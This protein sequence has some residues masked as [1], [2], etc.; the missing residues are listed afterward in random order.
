[1]EAIILAGGMGTRLSKVVTDVPKPMAPVNGKPFLLY[2]L[3]WIKKNPIEKIILSVGYKSESIV[4]YFGKSFNDIPVI[5]VIEEKPLG[6]GGALKFALKKTKGKNVLALNGDS[7]F[8]IDLNKFILEH[9]EN[10]HLFS[11]A[12][13]R[14]KGFSRYGSVK[15]LGNTI[16]KFNEKK[17]CHDGL[18]NGGIYLI[19][20]QFIE[21]KQLPEVFSLEKEILEKE[22][23][24]SVLKCMIFDDVFIDIGIPEDYLRAESILKQAR[25]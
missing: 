20:R 22:V 18:I 16:I 10:N 25:S 7:Y 4:N 3:Q 12:L 23:Q 6:T 24:T 1:M 15:C 19:N 9:S 13:K 21:S 17:F 2:L 8:P 14:M 5:Y 11:V